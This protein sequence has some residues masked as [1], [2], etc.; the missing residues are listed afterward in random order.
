MVWAEYTDL[1]RASDTRIFAKRRAG[2][3]DVVQLEDAQG[4]GTLAH[5]MELALDG[6][7]VYWS[8]PLIENGQWHGRLMHK[9][10]P[11]GPTEV[12]FV[13]PAGTIVTSPSVKDGVIAY[14]R[15][16]Q[17]GTPQTRVILR[18]RDG[19]ESEIGSAPSSEP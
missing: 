2:G 15:S 1:Q 5:L 10:L 19:S 16:G 3:G 12:V 18:L 9:R 13:A 11:D 4:H 6:V 7:D 8:L 17:W 14:E